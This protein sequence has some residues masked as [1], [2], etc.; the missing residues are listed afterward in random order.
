MNTSAIRKKL[1]SLIDTVDDKNAEAIYT[2][3]SGEADVESERMELIQAEREAYLRGEGK[4]Y[5]WEEVKE[6]ALNKDKR[7]VL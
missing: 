4:S 3:L 2:L 7:H 5:S 1:H 6:M